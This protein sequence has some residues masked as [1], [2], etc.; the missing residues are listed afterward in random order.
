MTRTLRRI[1]ALVVVVLAA[2]FIT[3]CDETTAAQRSQAVSLI[4]S[5]RTSRG[6][7]KLSQASDLNTKAGLW[8]AKMR[9]NCKLSHSK[10][11]DGVTLNWR[12]LGENVG[13][14][15]SVARVHDAFMASSGHRANILKTS[16]DKVGVGVATGRC[17]GRNVVYE[18][19]VFA[20][21]R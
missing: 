15:S 13:Y 3:G 2:V 21:V 8:A 14:S 10:L 19:Q 18:A 7:A 17:N 20:D 6:I 1:T 11:S 12:S 5:E 4:N 9:D 16:Y